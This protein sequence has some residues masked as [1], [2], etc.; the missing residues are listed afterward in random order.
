[1][2][3]IETLTS[4]EGRRQ[5]RKIFNE[6]RF[7]RQRSALS[8]LLICWRICAFERNLSKYIDEDV[9]VLMPLGIFR[10]TYLW[11]SE[12]VNRFYYSTINSFVYLGAAI[13]LILIGAR[14]FSEQ[15]S[16]EL[17]VA[18]IVFESLMLTVMFVVM[19]F[20]PNE[21][22]DE[23][24]DEDTTDQIVDEIGEIGRDFAAAVIQL[25]LIAKAM[26][27]MIDKQNLISQQ[28]VDNTLETHRL[29]APNHEMLDTMKETNLVLSDFKV[30]IES[31]NSQIKELRK[32]EIQFAVRKEL[33]SMLSS[34]L[35]QD[36]KE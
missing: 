30:S 16:N 17:V 33:E 34:K 20:T 4:I 27:I 23:I 14:R 26:N 6:L 3:N 25:D 8:T 12:I 36:E 9:R 19:F 1:M 28:L 31:L 35:M 10:G 15:V 2:K 11:M 21:D 18:G 29:T 32:E 22:I 5:L 24:D 7:V 13:L